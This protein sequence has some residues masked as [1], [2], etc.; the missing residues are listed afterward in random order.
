MWFMEQ[1]IIFAFS[2][3]CVAGRNSYQTFMKL[4]TVYGI[5]VRKTFQNIGEN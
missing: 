4:I 3:E 2:K 1:T 5:S